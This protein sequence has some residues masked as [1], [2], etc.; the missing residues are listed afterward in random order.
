MKK[1]R[2][3]LAMALFLAT[4]MSALAQERPP[5]FEETFED[6]ITGIPSGW[7][8]AGHLS[9]LARWSEFR[10]GVDGSVC[11]AYRNHRY[12]DTDYN[13]LVTPALDI[14]AGSMLSFD[15]S[16]PTVSGFAVYI[17]RDGGATFD[18]QSLTNPLSATAG[19]THSEFALPEGNIVLGFRAAGIAETKA[20]ELYLDNVRISSATRCAY[21]VNL[22]V[23]GVSDTSVSIVWNYSTVGSVSTL[24]EYEL[25]RDGILLTAKTF[26]ITAEP[27]CSL[28]SLD[29]NTT[30][31][32]RLRMDCSDSHL[33]H[34]RW[35]DPVYFTTACGLEELPLIYTFDDLTLPP[36]CWT[37]LLGTLPG[38]TAIS[39]MRYG[40]KGKSLEIA[41]S[42][43]NLFLF[44]EAIDHPANDME[45]SFYI[46]NSDTK[47]VT[48]EVGLQTD[49]YS[50]GTYTKID[51]IT[52]Q[53]SVWTLVALTTETTAHAA[54][55]GTMATLWFN[56]DFSAPLYI[57]NFLVRTTPPCLRPRTLAIDTFDHNSVTLQW[58]SRGETA[59]EV[60]NVLPGDTTLLGTVT[61]A[62]KQ[63]KGLTGDTPYTLWFR[64]V[65]GDTKSDWSPE[66]L[67]F[68]TLC[69]I[70][71]DL[72]L[73]EDFESG[74]LPNCWDMIPSTYNVRWEPSALR[75]HKG[76]YSMA[77]IPNDSQSSYLIMP[78][79]HIPADGHYQVEFYMYR[80]SGVEHMPDK[81][82][83]YAGTTPDVKTAQLLG[84]VNRVPSHEP[85]VSSDGWYKYEFNIPISGDIYIIFDGLSGG[86]SK[87]VFIDD[88]RISEVV[89]C[90]T[91]YGIKID[92][93][94]TS[95]CRIG[96]EKRADESRW[97]LLYKINDGEQIRQVVSDNPY[98][99]VQDL[100]PDTKYTFDISVVTLCAGDTHSDT[101]SNKISIETPCE[102]KQLDNDRF[103]ENFS[104][105]GWDCWTVLKEVKGYSYAG[106]QVKEGR[107][108]LS[109]WTLFFCMPEID[110]TD[111]TKYRVMFDYSS[112]KPDYYVLEVGIMS[113][114]EDHSSFTVL[115]TIK[116]TEEMA[117]Y[118]VLFDEYKGDGRIIAFRYT[119]DN[120]QGTSNANY[121][122]NVNVCLQPSCADVLN[123][124]FLSSTH[125][126]ADFI[127]P[128]S[129]TKTIEAQYG[130]S[131]FQLGEGTTVTVTK[132]RGDTVTVEGLQGST[133]YD[134]YFRV[135]CDET[136]KG[137]WSNAV[138]CLTKCT[139]VPVLSGSPIVDGF[140]HDGDWG[141]WFAE[142]NTKD[143]WGVDITWKLLNSEKDASEGSYYVQL[144][145]TMR[146]N[147]DADLYYPVDLKAGTQ[148]EF[149]CRVSSKTPVQI[150]AYCSSEVGADHGMQILTEDLKTDGYVQIKTY[151]TPDRDYSFIKIKGIMPKTYDA[152]MYLDDVKI[153]YAACKVPGGI[154]VGNITDAS[155]MI[156]VESHGGSWNL[157]VSST[158]IDP[159]TAEAD[160]FTKE[161][162][163]E[164][165]VTVPG[166][167]PNTKYYYYLQSVCE[168]EK[169]EWTDMSQFKTMCG[170]Q[171]LPYDQPFDDDSSLDCWMVFE[172]GKSA[173]AS[174]GGRTV[175]ELSTKS[176]VMF[177]SPALKSSEPDKTLADYMLNASFRSSVDNLEVAIGVMTDP[178]SPET[179]Q[180]IVNIDIPTKDQWVDILTYFEILRLPDME[181][182]RDAEYICI[183]FNS[184]EPD[185][186]SK[187]Y[188][189]DLQFSDPDDCPTPTAFRLS[190]VASDR[191]TVTWRAFA[192][193]AYKL[194]VIKGGEIVQ[195]LDA[196]GNSKE[197]ALL[198][199]N[200]AY[201]VELY[202]NCTPKYSDTVSISFTTLCDAYELPFRE[203][204]DHLGISTISMPD[205]WSNDVRKPDEKNNGWIE[206][207]YDNTHSVYMKFYTYE[208]KGNMSILQT[209]L[210]NLTDLSDAILSFSAK[211]IDS[212]LYVL[213]STDGRNFTDTLAKNVGSPDWTTFEYRLTKYAGQSIYIGFCGVTTANPVRTSLIGIDD[214]FVD[215]SSECAA[216][217][218]VTVTEIAATQVTLDIVS[219]ASK[220]EILYGAP[221][222]DIAKPQ[223]VPADSKT[224]VIDN[225]SDGTDYEFYVRSVCDDN[226]SRLVGPYFFSTA[227]ALKT[228]S[229][230]EDF[231]DIADIASL[232]CYGVS[233][234]GKIVGGGVSDFL[235][236]N[237][238]KSFCFQS[239]Y[240]SAYEYLVLPPLD[241]D[242]E[243]LMMSFYAMVGNETKVIE[244]GTVHSDSVDDIS[245]RF[246]PITEIT[247]GT[248]K[249]KFEVYLDDAPRSGKNY[250]VAIRVNS[251]YTTVAFDDIHI[252]LIPAFGKPRDVIHSQLRDTS[253]V[254]S[255]LD[256]P[257]A[258]GAELMLD[259]D[260]TKLYTATEDGR[261]FFD[262][263]T[264]DKTYTVNV[265]GT[266]GEGE[267]KQTTEWS[268][269]YSFTTLHTP[270]VSP[271]VCKFESDDTESA[272]WCMI[273]DR[274][275]EFRWVVS[276]SDK[277]GIYQGKQAL[278]IEYED[279]YSG[280][281][282]I[283]LGYF[284]Q[285][286]FSWAYRTL[287]LES[288]V[289]YSVDFV[290]HVEG[291]P[292]K[293]D[294]FRAYIAPVD[295]FDPENVVVGDQWIALSDELKGKSAWTQFSERFTVETSGY[296]HLVLCWHNA[297]GSNYQ[298]PILTS[299]VDSL[300]FV[301][302]DCAAIEDIAVDSITVSSAKVTWR[303]DNRTGVV[304]RYAVIPADQEFNELNADIIETDD[305][306]AR[307]NDLDADTD[308]KVYISARCVN[309]SNPGWFSTDV[310]STLCLPVAVGDDMAFKDDFEE[311]AEHDLGC[312]FAAD[313]TKWVA[314]RDNTQQLYPYHG[315]T[316][317]ILASGETSAIYHAF[318]LQENKNYHLS[319][320]ARKEANGYNGTKLSVS[321]AAADQKGETLVGTHD[322]HS[323]EYVRLENYFTVP[324]SGSYTVCLLGE[325][326]ATTAFLSIDS[327]LLEVVDC[328]VPSMFTV[329]DLTATSATI[330]WSGIADAFSVTVDGGTLHKT[331]TVEANSIK[332]DVLK[333]S[334]RY[335]LRINAADCPD[336]VAVFSF[337]T[338][339]DGATS[340]PYIEDFDAFESL[341]ACWD[342]TVG[343]A[344]DAYRWNFYRTSDG[345]GTLRFDSHEA[346]RG[347]TNTLQSPAIAIPTDAAGVYLSF[348]Y[349]NAEGGDMHVMISTDGGTSVADTLL[350]GVRKVREWNTF[351]TS[352]AKYAGK[353]ITFMVSSVS[354]Y[355][356]SDEAYHYIDN[357][358]IMNISKIETYP[359]T[360]CYG[361]PYVANGFDIAPAL[362]DYGMNTF[363]RIEM[364]DDA[365]AVRHIANVYV[366]ATDYYI[367]D[368]VESGKI[369]NGN[370]FENIAKP[371][372]DYVMEHTSKL[373]GCD[374]IVHLNLVEIVT[375]VTVR[376][377][378]CEGKS[379]RFCGK[380]ETTAG[381]YTCTE[382][383]SAGVADSTTTL[384]LT[385]LPRE[386][387]VY[388]TICQGDVCEFNGERYTEA[389]TYTFDDK[390]NHLGCDSIVHLHLHV[391]DSVQPMSHEMCQGQ[392]F[393]V[394]NQK[395]DSTGIYRILLPT[396]KYGCR[397]V[398]VLDLK[399]NAPDTISLQTVACEGKPIFVDGFAGTIVTK[400]TVMYRTDRTDAGC[401]SVTRL[402][403]TFNPTTH[404]YDTVTINQGD[405]YPYGDGDDRQTLTTT[406]DYSSSGITS[407]YGC[408]SI[409]HLRLIVLEGTGI[410][411][412]TGIHTIVLAPNPVRKY[413]PSRLDIDLTEDEMRHMTIELLDFSGKTIRREVI[414]RLPAQIEGISES[415]IYFV[416]LTTASGRVYIGKLIVR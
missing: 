191:V 397:P 358:R 127:I 336:H 363:T 279:F 268:N 306:F 298:K 257:D 167:T 236:V 379:Y 247:A 181:D 18:E 93:V 100:T 19:W 404:V 198:E 59:L 389:N 344:A 249:N 331:E 153:K 38:S 378:I 272:K 55:R 174:V 302:V 45:I 63:I 189:D 90:P 206:E 113:S 158:P 391:I 254:I 342:N 92:N 290:Y 233:S 16:S 289:Q 283:C 330:S 80:E 41:A 245:A 195:T 239:N 138:P 292:N 387:N 135:V 345:N 160:I 78:K 143:V 406:G 94:T 202:T 301:E 210:L 348:D 70:Y 274:S 15:Y 398:V 57:D 126:S 296:Y 352:L 226:R 260:D 64:S 314:N 269:A 311:C 251:G 327:I 172:E 165:F 71:T 39:S 88:V 242:I 99:D 136:N 256:S 299:A 3:F 121:I 22:S 294:Y 227:C 208:R 69:S 134:V 243:S 29:P 216:P 286:T 145:P 75:P 240:S 163:T 36:N 309:G 320:Y 60:Y 401:D 224:A 118:S 273:N 65:C 209:P 8:N 42:Q 313:G 288:A 218:E 151:F 43:R 159:A 87:T 97:A 58:E 106:A 411:A 221:G 255:W 376:A 111:I 203:N 381:T 284:D 105:T 177:I 46:Y 109:G 393:E 304:Y 410:D 49:I 374:S 408:D 199:A 204:F 370:G 83:V 200:T 179:Y 211:G 192:D 373:T 355:S 171:P 14:P 307:L 187:L 120:Y 220:W 24:A 85:V 219:S 103:T 169:S 356:L 10:G 383:N 166:L 31:S 175:V 108:S 362:I 382:R 364:S 62:D 149:S 337:S 341:P 30:Y 125:S 399:V 360:I 385:V 287:D 142:G 20:L 178:N 252:D 180:N 132:Q 350:A 139:P 415:G 368:Y 53:P 412:L 21:P 281:S 395:F 361:E 244:I 131:G 40:T 354:N 357:I 205:C 52:A 371:G 265:R 402:D 237:G 259:G 407:D 234:N 400:D 323:S 28:T 416:R 405:V 197:I 250:R 414:D 26:N 324:A 366:P 267:A 34:S 161:G 168:Q 117:T 89:D 48:I 325:V 263:L 140:E 119:G 310:F 396:D 217:E 194:D 215:A 300:V 114:M 392:E 229:F 112:Y 66:H 11:M 122:D 285:S 347:E 277:A 72:P 82:S 54:A 130:V 305:A 317:L 329:S 266:K 349:K 308:Y 193:A 33:G 148:Y 214:I 248:S 295:Q 230:T 2:L 1:I 190:D 129:S 77:L 321:L 326:A 101:A 403:V 27:T 150:F 334:T 162:I 332:L 196:S 7:D 23:A 207:P 95:S 56:S 262:A 264:A 98:Y 144:Q 275:G 102:I 377:E 280:K 68:R 154:S 164:P 107:L 312:W 394:G 388:D 170:R 61:S 278:Y 386:Y 238:T 380:D 51:Q 212:S 223:I 104:S 141:C 222:F 367:T 338:S 372:S 73:T 186:E 37:S 271:S 351:A 258:T 115:G 270:A 333:P 328:V 44:S 137:A 235:V 84:V 176:R 315:L 50:T 133:L 123:M 369:Y 156:M 375:A 413:E 86:S 225:L 409:H 74:V 346:G 353:Q 293:N 343:T 79:M 316:N 67:T 155:A 173:I 147:A 390:P 6:V 35:S 297:A 76:S 339:C 335:T 96:W 185:K 201:T 232:H 152:Y 157:K 9:G 12:T 261:F 17:S 184:T 319:L 146:D 47:P 4:T 5:L 318:D 32:L 340:I 13:I 276:G 182:F 188:I 213:V 282:H 291:A 246:L 25:Y 384:I 241:A 253:V 303:S 81:V 110:I 359:D 231:E 91:S 322:I 365:S 124:S 128:N 183:T 228:L 116:G